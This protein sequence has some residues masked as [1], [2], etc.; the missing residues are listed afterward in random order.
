VDVVTYLALKGLFL[1][2]SLGSVPLL[3][4]QTP[5]LSYPFWEFDFLKLQ[6]FF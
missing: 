1:S 2:C 4:I 3:M 5:G 6:T